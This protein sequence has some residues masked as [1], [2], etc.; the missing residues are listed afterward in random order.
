MVI[1]G[2]V[3]V[4]AGGQYRQIAT[5]LGFLSLPQSKGGF[6]IPNDQLDTLGWLVRADYIVSYLKWVRRRSDGILH[7]GLFTLLDTM[8]A[9]LRPRTGYVWLTPSL[10][11]TLPG[12]EWPG[13]IP[14]DRKSVV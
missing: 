14:R 12:S 13:G 2:G 10:A 11:N 1:D 7:D 6:G 8:R 9:H 5:F 3:C 4:T